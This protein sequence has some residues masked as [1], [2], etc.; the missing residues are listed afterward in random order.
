MNMKKWI[1]FLSC[2]N[3]KVMEEKYEWGVGISTEIGF[4]VRI[5]AG[6]IGTTGISTS[7]TASFD[8]PDDG[9]GVGY[10]ESS[11]ESHLPKDIDIVWL[12]YVEDCFY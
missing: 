10:R 4:P 3:D 8:K 9:W 6:R 2:Q 5:Y 11:S 7:F 1:Q 12:S